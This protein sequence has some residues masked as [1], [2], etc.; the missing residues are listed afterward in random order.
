MGTAA[1][2]SRSASTA[3]GP[4]DDV[5]DVLRAVMEAIPA[6]VF[7]KD[8]DLVYRACNA[9][10]AAYLGRPAEDVVGKTVYDIAPRH[11]AETYDR[12]DRD[13]LAQGGTQI[14]E[15]QMRYADGSI[16]DISFHKALFRSKAGNLRGMIGVMLDITP[17]KRAE[18]ALR[19]REESLRLLLEATDEGIIAA[20]MECRCTLANPAAARM[21]GAGTAESLQ[22]CCLCAYVDPAGVDMEEGDHACSVALKI[23]EG[24][25]QRVIDGMFRRRTGEIFPV[26]YTISPMFREDRLVGAV[27]VFSDNT[28]RRQLESQLYQASKMEALGTLA[29]G[30]AHEINTPIQYIGDNLSFIEDSLADVVRI[31]DG[32]RGA[33]AAA[34]AERG[35]PRAEAQR[36]LDEGNA[37]FLMEELPAAIGQSRDGVAHVSHIVQSM[38]EFSH[39]GGQSKSLADLNH[40]VENTCLVTTNIWKHVARLDA[41]LAEGPINVPCHAVDISQ[42]L[43][44][45]I[46]NA[47]QAIEAEGRSGLGLITVSTRRD[48]D[49]AEI[50]VSDDGPGVPPEICGRIFDPFFTTKPAGKGTGQGLAISF[51]V[52]TRR[53]G[54]S[55]SLVPGAAGRGACFVVRLPM[56]A[57]SV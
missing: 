15:T 56:E 13:L 12:A 9:A 28:Q 50:R 5:L 53:H 57:K 20:D 7:F 3:P 2:S 27:L 52:V 37:A 44:N 45:L 26:D 10:F 51:D 30:I 22:G 24:R 33:A 43:L 41:D 32:L 55:L 48:G 8:E 31:L 38:R 47:A 18:S 39:P 17:G 11:L 21:L 23:R 1:P 6:P 42:V 25:P 34:D 19:E 14:Y 40:L 49:M 4:G 29:A 54:G 46:V 35:I 36:L 16:R